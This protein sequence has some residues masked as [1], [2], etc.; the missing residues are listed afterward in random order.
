[1]GNFREVRNVNQNVRFQE[2][3]VC[4]WGYSKPQQSIS[5]SD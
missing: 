1:M 4:L 5:K 2:G 3:A